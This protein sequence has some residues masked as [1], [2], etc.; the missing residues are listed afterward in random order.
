[1]F[2]THL[3]RIDGVYVI[4]VPNEF[5][6]QQD[7]REGQAISITVEAIEEYA[8]V[9]PDADGMAQPTWKLNESASPTYATDETSD[10]SNR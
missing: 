3:K 4:A 2:V 8:H 6:V 9:E 5:I 10:R 1:M 7:L